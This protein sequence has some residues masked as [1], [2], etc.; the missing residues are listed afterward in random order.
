MNFSCVPSYGNRAVAG[1][2]LNVKTLVVRHNS[3]VN[4][5]SPSWVSVKYCLC[6]CIYFTFFG[7]KYLLNGLCFLFCWYSVIIFL[8][9]MYSVCIVNIFRA[10]PP[11]FWFYCKVVIFYPATLQRDSLPIGSCWRWSCPNRFWGWKCFSF[12]LLLQKLSKYSVLFA[13]LC[14][15]FSFFF[16]KIELWIEIEVTHYTCLII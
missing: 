15:S 6:L 14:I 11:F 16:Q 7:I 5:I 1:N 3:S 12:I 9:F 2:I 4:S 8:V 10:L 13:I